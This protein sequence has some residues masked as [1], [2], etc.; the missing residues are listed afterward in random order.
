MHL[1]EWELGQE[2]MEKQLSILLPAL[3]DLLTLDQ[4]PLWL[5]AIEKDSQKMGKSIS[6]T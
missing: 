5:L 1:E 4:E 2:K 6:N 3:V